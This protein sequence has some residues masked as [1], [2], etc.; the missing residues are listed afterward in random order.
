MNLTSLTNLYDIRIWVHWA[1]IMTETANIETKKYEGLGGWLIL[2]LLGLIIWPIRNIIELVPLYA[3]FMD[4][5]AWKVLFDAA[6]EAY[7]PPLAFLLIVEILINLML[8][9]AN[10]VAVI[11]FFQ[12]R[13][14]FP[15]LYICILAG[16][17]IFILLDTLL[18][19]YLLPT[20]DA[21]DQETTKEII[22]SIVGAFIWISYILVSKRVEATFVH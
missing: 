5:A 17:A 19:S 16:S 14:A 3:P 1:R 2:V 21:F 20:A 10:G 18:V 9:V 6:S 4:I 22:R 13:S 8:L 11:F 12:K 15:K 7:N